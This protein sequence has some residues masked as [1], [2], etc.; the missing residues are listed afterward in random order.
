[1]IDEP[2]LTFKDLHTGKPK[3][4]TCLRCFTNPVEGQFFIQALRRDAMNS[5]VAATSSSLCRECLEIVFRAIATS[6]I[7]PV[8]FGKDQCPRCQ[9]H[10]TVIGRIMLMAR[11]QDGNFKQGRQPKYTSIANDTYRYCESCTVYAY[12]SAVGLRDQLLEE[13]HV[14]KTETPS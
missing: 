1:M 10:K 12:R 6:L 3:R 13:G 4:G 5:P 11:I 2:E 14:A 9:K 7:Q 8:V